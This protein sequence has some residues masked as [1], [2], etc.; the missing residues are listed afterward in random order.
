VNLDRSA[1]WI[2][3]PFRPRPEGLT[4]MPVKKGP[5][6]PSGVFDLLKEVLRDSVDLSQGICRHDITLWTSDDEADVA[7]AAWACRHSCPVFVRCSTW[8]ADRPNSVTGVVAAENYRHDPNKRL[9]PQIRKPI[10]SEL[11]CSR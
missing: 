10:D 4:A 6:P 1:Q 7:L 3:A 9:R 11:A 8:I 2:W 5:Q